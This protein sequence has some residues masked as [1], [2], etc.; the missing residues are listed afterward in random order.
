[1]G[2]HT[3]KHKLS[4]FLSVY[5]GAGEKQTLSDNNFQSGLSEYS[6]CA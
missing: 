4:L 6:N 1:M 3:F 2:K 5:N